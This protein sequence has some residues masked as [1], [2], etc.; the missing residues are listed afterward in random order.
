MSSRIDMQTLA[1]ILPSILYDHLT[2]SISASWEPD[3]D[4]MSTDS[5]IDCSSQFS[6][7]Q[8]GQTDRQADRSQTQLITIH[9]LRLSPEWLI[10]KVVREQV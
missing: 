2:F 3:K 5:R 10:T 8:H 7:L 4:Y 6:F 9:T 1:I